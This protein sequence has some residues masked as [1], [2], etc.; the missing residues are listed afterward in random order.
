MGGRSNA[1]RLR[2]A[3]RE[4]TNKRRSGPLSTLHCVRVRGYTETG[5]LIGDFQ[6]RIK[7]DGHWLT[8]RRAKKMCKLLGATSIIRE[9]IW[10]V[11]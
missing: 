6:A 8:P 5:E 2:R 10:E 4:K 1:R 7:I 11:A 9:N 3:N